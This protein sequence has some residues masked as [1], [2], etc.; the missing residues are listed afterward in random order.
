MVD[1][2]G[3]PGNPREAEP[4]AVL[5]FPR[6]LQT[7][8][9]RVQQ[10]GELE[11]TKLT[12]P[13]APFKAPANVPFLVAQAAS[14]K[15]AN[16]VQVLGAVRSYQLLPVDPDRKV[17]HINVRYTTG[18]AFAAIFGDQSSVD[19][20]VSI[21]PAAAAGYVP[22]P[23]TFL[24]AAAGAGSSGGNPTLEYTSKQSLWCCLGT[25]A[26]IGTVLFVQCMVEKFGSGTPIN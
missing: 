17:A 2:A 26:D 15:F 19:N 20:Y 14:D 25:S 22:A 1:E 7:L 12:Q 18:A 11:G 5:G 8:G 10:P 4:T 16:V 9:D 6:G 24:I 3:D 21:M 13:H 23:G